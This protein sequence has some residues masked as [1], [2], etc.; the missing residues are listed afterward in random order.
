MQKLA[1]TTPSRKGQCRSLKALFREIRL[2]D[3]RKLKLSLGGRSSV[4]IPFSA[5]SSLGRSENVPSARG[6]C[7]L[8]NEIK[9][10]IRVA[11]LMLSIEAKKDRRSSC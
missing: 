4:S 2:S 5:S 10:I 3:L 11:H 1:N 8:S 7:L 9:L 6:C